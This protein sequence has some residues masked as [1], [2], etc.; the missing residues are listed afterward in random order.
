MADISKL[1]IENVVYTIKDT[2]SRAIMT[3]ATSSSGG[4][5]GRV[6]APAIENRTQYLRGDGSW[7]TPP[8]VSSITVSGT[9]L[10]IS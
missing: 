8:G 10:I 6:P 5:A 3:G 4:H 7:A 9:T 1:K 2:V